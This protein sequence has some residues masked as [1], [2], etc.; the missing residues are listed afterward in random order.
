[1]VFWMLCLHGEGKIM[2]FVKSTL[3]V[4]L[5]AALTACGG[6]SDGGS[7]SNGSGN[8]DGN[9]N[10]NGNQTGGEIIISGTVTKGTMKQATV[11]PYK[12]VD[13]S[14]VKIPES[15]IESDS[16]LITDNK[17]FYSFNVPEYSGPVKVELQANENTLMV[18]DAVD[19]C[20][21]IA[22][23]ADI[24]L[25]TDFKL[26]SVSN[27][28]ES[29]EQITLNV[30]ALTHIAG[31]LI[32]NDLSSLDA[33]KIQQ[34]NS[35]IANAFGVQ[36]DITQLTSTN[37][38]S[39]N[40]DASVDASVV[41][42]AAVNQKAE[43]KYA[44]V[45]A[46]IASALYKATND[47]KNIAQLLDEATNDIVSAGG[48]IAVKSDNTSGSFVLTTNDVLVAAAKT[49]DEKL[50]PVVEGDTAVTDALTG[51]ETEVMSDKAEN[52]KNA[53]EDGRIEPEAS[54]EPVDATPLDKAKAMI[55]DVRVLTELL[56][57]NETSDSTSG[58][59]PAV[60]QYETLLLNANAMVEA[61]SESFTL[62]EEIEFVLSD[63]NAAFGEVIEDGTL[64]DK[65]F[66][67]A[68]FGNKN[69]TGSI[70][71]DADLLTFK[72]DNIS[73]AM[74]GTGAQSSTANKADGSATANLTAKIMGFESD[75]SGQEFSLQLAGTLTSSG[76]VFTFSNSETS[77]IKVKTSNKIVREDFD[78][79]EDV[80]A[81]I[82]EISVDL[83]L[84][85]AQQGVDN[86]VTFSGQLTGTLVPQT[87]LKVRQGWDWDESYYYVDK[88]ETAI[89]ELFSLVGEFS[90]L[91]G[92]AVSAALTVNVDN[93]REFETQG[94]DGFGKTVADVANVAVGADQKTI[95]FSLDDGTEV[96]ELA[97]T[98]DGDSS[99]WT[100]TFNTR[101]VDDSQTTEIESFRTIELGESSNPRYVFTYVEAEAGE[102][103]VWAEQLVVEPNNGQYDIYYIQDVMV[104][105]DDYLG[106]DGLLKSSEG[107]Q[108]A[109]ADYITYQD[110]Y[111]SFDDFLHY[112]YLAEELFSFGDPRQIN[113][114]TEMVSRAQANHP[115]Y[116]IFPVN[117]LGTVQLQ[118]VE[119]TA[120]LNTS[121]N[122]Y[123]LND[124]YEGEV[125]VEADEDLTQVD[126]SFTQTT[127]TIQYKLDKT[128]DDNYVFTETWTVEDRS[129]MDTITA[130]TEAVS[131]I[132][133][134]EKY[135]LVHVAGVSD[136]DG[137]RYYY[138]F[139]A[140][141]TPLDNNQ[142]GMVDDYNST[143]EYCYVYHEDGLSSLADC[144]WEMTMSD[145]GT[146]TTWYYGQQ[147]NDVV[148]AALIY[149][150]GN[151]SYSTYIDNVGYIYSESLNIASLREQKS[152]LLYAYLAEPE[153]DTG[154]E[155]E[156][157]YLDIFASLAL[158]IKVDG[159]DV[160]LRLSG[161]RNGI[162]DG[163]ITLDLDY[164]LADNQGTRE[165]KLS[166]NT[167]D[168]DDDGYVTS[169]KANNNAGVSL[170]L[171]EPTKA[172][173]EQ[174]GDIVLGTIM[175][176]GEQTGEVIYRTENSM[177]FVKFS[178]DSIV[179][180]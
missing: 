68:D 97:G 20:G 88:D 140:I 169:L 172:Q 109:L 143:E 28:N 163:L 162:E 158:G 100:S 89:P 36:G 121:L 86:P 103:E 9:G 35:K 81:Q 66:N 17:G 179:N 137:E 56:G 62:L 174:G 141:V 92:D 90:S 33:Q 106:T 75:A 96:T 166:F 144:N 122:G 13:N 116:F 77:L 180:L 4:A 146:P 26:S 120:G 149:T 108:L 130:S 159:Y 23:G 135:T 1:M 18:C 110:D 134:A 51:L 98:Y 155:T 8:G 27:I 47:N 55:T 30:S 161:N 128:S 99:N 85:L 165:V 15:E 43:L 60:E 124:F 58:F 64:K 138:G 105:L 70:S 25:P 44:L 16:G 95:T 156:S 173:K 150:F 91:E 40:A 147:I 119:Y 111:A 22:F 93:A 152:Q 115:E 168:V 154:F 139:R 29:D 153:N 76:A 14:W 32:S 67:A 61:E 53:G 10:G 171:L 123:L 74:S 104:K 49:A 175:A 45:N 127:D 94:F 72:L 57:I 87:E 52:E 112:S 69:L 113:N 39:D 176:D 101:F 164:Q 178:D 142:D 131:G 133:D 34:Q 37:F 125:T 50:K 38:I 114:I 24:Q 5:I 167:K 82:D 63:I 151:N 71:F 107:N 118:P 177:L 126:I 54:N 2:K 145:D 160:N 73:Y 21:D 78:A 80:D 7:D 170:D 136:D 84:Q 31:E 48:S 117:V 42:D 129:E 6:G 11:V 157:N 19:G 3:S 59:A 41:S 132:S 79:E 102:N 12:L 148:D 83:S 46:G 65:T